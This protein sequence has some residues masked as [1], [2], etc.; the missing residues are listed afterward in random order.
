MVYAKPV[1]ARLTGTA[2]QVEDGPSPVT[3][4]WVEQHYP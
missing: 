1:E 4:P 2:V 3:A